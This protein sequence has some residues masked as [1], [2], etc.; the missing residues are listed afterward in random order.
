MVHRAERLDEIIILANKYKLN[1][2]E[3]QFISTKK[4]IIIQ[5]LF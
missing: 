1:V 3:I 4:R 2:K 5:V